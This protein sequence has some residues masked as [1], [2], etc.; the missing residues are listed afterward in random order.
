[1]IKNI[2][3]RLID[4]FGLNP[5]DLFSEEDLIAFSPMVKVDSEDF[6]NA[7]GAVIASKKALFREGNSSPIYRFPVYRTS[8]RIYTSEIEEGMIDTEFRE[9]N[10][11]KFRNSYSCQIGSAI[12]VFPMNSDLLD[13]IS[14]ED[15]FTTT[16]LDLLLS[17]LNQMLDNSPYLIDL[18]DKI[19]FMQGYLFRKDIPR[20]KVVWNP[21]Y[22]K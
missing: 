3:K 4:W 7:L 5:K 8:N 13:Y 1:M 11:N 18:R 16:E 12:F 2:V 20:D 19:Y 14:L 22:T 9:V 6:K 21:S 10:I 17:A 15:I